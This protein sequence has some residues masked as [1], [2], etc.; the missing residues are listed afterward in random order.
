MQSHINSYGRQRN[1]QYLSNSYRKQGTFKRYHWFLVPTSR[2]LHVLNPHI[3]S[4]L[5]HHFVW[6][7]AYICTQSY[8]K[9]YVFHVLLGIQ[10]FQLSCLESKK[11]SQIKSTK[12]FPAL[13]QIRI[14]NEHTIC[15]ILSRISNSSC[16]KQLSKLQVELARHICTLHY[17]YC[18]GVRCAQIYIKCHKSKQIVSETFEFFSDSKLTVVYMVNF[19]LFE[20]STRLSKRV[21]HQGFLPINNYAKAI[22]HAKIRHKIEINYDPCLS[23]IS[24]ART[25]TKHTKNLKKINKKMYSPSATMSKVI[26][27]S[28][29]HLI[30][31]S[32]TIVYVL[33][34]STQSPTW[35][36]VAILHIILAEIAVALA[37]RDAATDGKRSHAKTEQ[38]RAPSSSPT[39]I[40]NKSRHFKSINQW[41]TVRLGTDREKMFQKLW[42]SNVSDL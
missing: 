38:Q 11:R 42:C 17:I 40:Q 3:H 9:R 8:S 33:K 32:N 4:K 30:Y 16:S 22:T 14:W 21:I 31:M 34:I 2:R 10:N 29:N 1:C 20:L 23:F 24:F 7:S 26:T 37:E 12:M 28:V 19:P 35:A 41:S 25:N 5:N 36:D 18:H 13:L 6:K 27:S 15:F 39:K